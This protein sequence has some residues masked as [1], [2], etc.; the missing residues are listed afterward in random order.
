MWKKSDVPDDDEVEVP[1]EFQ[2][3][4]QGQVFVA[5]ELDRAVARAEV[6]DRAVARAK[7]LDHAVEPRSWIAP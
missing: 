1:E 5:E 6:L 3:V 2:N 4:N 7:E